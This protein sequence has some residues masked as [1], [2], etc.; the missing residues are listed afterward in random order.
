MPFRSRIKAERFL[1]KSTSPGK[2]S[3]MYVAYEAI[4]ILEKLPLQIESIAA[5]GIAIFYLNIIFSGK[6]IFLLLDEHLLVG[7]HQGHLLMYSVLQGMSNHLD[8]SS[9]KSEVHLLRSNKYFARKPI[10]QLAVVPEHQ[11]LI[12][13]SGMFQSMLYCF[14]L[15]I[16]FLFHRL[17]CYSP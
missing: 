15:I 12:C 10:Q 7:T 4:P 11:I 6:L 13:L 14:F 16:R 3:K 9:P 8:C 17:D 2:H 5:Y 1:N